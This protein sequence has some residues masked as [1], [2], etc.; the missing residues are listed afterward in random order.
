MFD[1]SVPIHYNDDDDLELKIMAHHHVATHLVLFHALF[2]IVS[3][4]A[5][6]VELFN[7]STFVVIAWLWFGILAHWRAVEHFRK[8]A[9]SY[10]YR[11]SEWRDYYGSAA[12]VVL[13]SVMAI[14]GCVAMV[15]I[16]NPLYTIPT[17]VAYTNEWIHG[18][19]VVYVCWPS[20]RK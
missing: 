12:S 11:E 8:V 15:Y 4:F 1:T 6:V 17:I 14:I 9:A 10:A 18:V 7:G 19:L 13:A 20:C 5:F 3:I 16:S 2:V